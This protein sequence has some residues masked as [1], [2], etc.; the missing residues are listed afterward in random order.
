MRP[1]IVNR[2]SRRRGEDGYTLVEL[3]VSMVILAM[4]GMALVI[5]VV[6]SVRAE[7]VGTD[8][9]N[10]LGDVRT[11]IERL[12]RDIREARAVTCDGAAWDPTCQSHLQLWID[13]N[14]N[15]EIDS[16]TEIVTWQLTP[17]G[18]GIHFEVTRTVNGVTS[19]VARS[20]IVQVAF[21][22]DSQP[23]SAETSPTTTV[24][25]TM[26]YDTLVGIGTGSRQLNFTERLRNVA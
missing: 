3:L 18:D 15:Y 10:G 17:L 22:Y 8:E 4:L 21:T 14:S 25:T 7:T 26:T 9:S 2:L 24:T 23:T 5:G 16:A 20:L 11:V 1:T 12:G 6:T 13:Y 19:V